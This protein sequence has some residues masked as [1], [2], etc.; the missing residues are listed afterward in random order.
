MKD[1]SFLILLI[2]FITAHFINIGIAIDRIE[3]KID[4]LITRKGKEKG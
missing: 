3:D 1:F 4:K 2:L